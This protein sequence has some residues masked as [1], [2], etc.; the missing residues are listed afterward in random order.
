MNPYR[1]ITSEDIRQL[2]LSSQV[3]LD[4]VTKAFCLK[5][6]CQLP[7]KISLHP[8]N[9]D[10]FNTMPCLLPPAYHRFGVKIVSRINGR[11][12]ALK[13]DLL[14]YDSESGNLLA[15]IDSDWITATRTGA[16]ATLAIKTLRN[17]HARIYGFIG[18][19]STGK[20]T[21]RCLLETSPEE[22]MT[23]RLFRYKNHAEKVIEEFGKFRN[24]HFVITDTLEELVKD[25][26][27]IVS[28]VTEA[29]GL[30]VEDDTL[31]KPG[32]LVVPVHT[33]GFQNC[34]LTFDKVFADDTAHVC[35][36]K[37][38]DRFREYH[39]LEEVLKGAIPGRE[40]DNERILS[41]NIGLGLHDVFYASNIYK[42]LTEKTNQN[43]I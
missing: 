33:R 25:T 41:Y 1:I 5:S 29:N 39:Q 22:E 18:L 21:L 7:P 32:V 16:V 6:E 31:F 27:V 38:F 10:F 17:S 37:Y 12:P 26:D 2:N 20:S 15:M 4:W 30:F 11:I 35:G 14:L 43:A 13:S 34:D 42:I 8:Q 28:C 23:V 9:N 40:N 3:C 36:F 19:G 24:V